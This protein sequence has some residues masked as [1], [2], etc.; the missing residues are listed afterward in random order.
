MTSRSSCLRAIVLVGVTWI[1]GRAEAQG[2]PQTSLE[3]VLVYAESHA[4]LLLA[5]RARL[6]EGV[7]A[8]E[9]AAPLLRDGLSVSFGAG[10]RLQ[11]D[12]QGDA[13]MLLAISQPIEIGAQRGTRMN[14]AD[15]LLAQRDAELEAARWQV[16]REIHLAY[17]HALHDRARVLSEDGWIVLAQEVLR[18]ATARSTVGEGAAIEQVIANA[19]LAQARQ[20]RLVALA[21]FQSAILTLAEVSGWDASNPPEPS[22]NLD[23]PELLPTDEQLIATAIEHQPLVRALAASIATARADITREER[24]AI[25]TLQV[26]LQ[27]SREGAAGAPANYIGLLILGVAFPVWQ[28]NTEARAR[29]E[30]AMA[31]AQAQSDALRATI[32]ARVRRAASTVRLSAERL[33]VYETAVLPGFEAALAGLTRAYEVGEID[34]ATLNAGRQTLHAVQVDALDAYTAY[35]DALAELETELGT[36]IDTQ[37]GATAPAETD[38]GSR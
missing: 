20:R 30:A 2:P 16:H 11:E 15:R 38:G 8:Q 12:G 34:L 29:A 3:D 25:P 37:E 33:R 27:F 32:D 9:G 22:G 36:E 31:I 17:H 10:P 21:D 6:E 5:A 24:E 13:D 1:C 35:H 28:Q 14:A 19:E 26:G 23:A 7:A 18:I 4:P